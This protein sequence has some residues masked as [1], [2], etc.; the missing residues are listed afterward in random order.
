M[1]PEEYEVIEAGDGRT[2][3]QRIDDSID[4]VLLDR[5]MPKLSGETVAE[6]LRQRS[7]TPAVVMISSV[8]PD[9]DTGPSRPNCHSLEEADRDTLLSVLSAS[10]APVR[11]RDGRGNSGLADRRDTVA[12]EYGQRTRGERRVQAGR[13]TTGTTRRITPDAVS[14]RRAHC[15]PVQSVS[16]S[17]PSAMQ[18][19]RSSRARETEAA[20]EPRRR[21]RGG[22]PAG[23]SAA[24]ASAVHGADA[25]LL[26]QGAREPTARSPG[27]DSTDAAG[28]LEY[29][30]HQAISRGRSSPKTWC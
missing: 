7:V 29:G 23:S 13:R 8:K 4:A 20:M 27:P 9:V 30:R 17:D 10:S 28:L 19:N 11:I 22:G 12:D 18:D 2:G 14:G 5:Q 26:D 1:A 6:K 21:P 15:V 3:L 24:E 25:V 16:A